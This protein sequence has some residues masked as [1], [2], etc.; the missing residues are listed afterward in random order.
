MRPR[1]SLR[2][3]LFTIFFG[4]IIVSACH[5]KIVSIYHY[6]SGNA[7]RDYFFKRGFEYPVYTDSTKPICRP[8]DVE[9]FYGVHDRRRKQLAAQAKEIIRQKFLPT[10]LSD[11]GR[12]WAVFPVMVY[13]PDSPLVLYRVELKEYVNMNKGGVPE[14]GAQLLDNGHIQTRT[15]NIEFEVMPDGALEY[16]CD[17]EM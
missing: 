5:P 14:D 15:R 3:S 10:V 16:R 6:P 1:F 11:S 13:G 7:V 9:R 12:A 4:L 8:E 2:F 17:Q